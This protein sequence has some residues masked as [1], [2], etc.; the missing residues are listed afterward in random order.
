LDFKYPHRRL[1]NAAIE[2][3]FEEQRNES[4]HVGFNELYRKSLSFLN[5]SP[6]DYGSS[7]SERPS[8]KTFSH[9]LEKMEEEKI[10]K[11]GLK[12]RPNHSDFSLTNDAKIMRG[13]NILGISDDKMIFTKVYE[14]ILLSIVF[15]MP[16]KITPES[17]DEFLST[18]RA[19]RNGLPL[20][21]S[22][23]D[24]LNLSNLKLKY[25][26]VE[27][28]LNLNEE[29]NKIIKKTLFDGDMRF[30]LADDNLHQLIEV[31]GHLFVDEMSL[32][33]CKWRHFSQPS[34]EEK[35]RLEWLVGEDISRKIIRDAEIYRYDN[36]IARKSKRA[37]KRSK[38][39]EEYIKH[40]KRGNTS[41]F[42]LSLID[43]VFELYIDNKRK[44]VACTRSSENDI[45]EFFNVLHNRFKELETNYVNKI[46][47]VHQKYKDT[48]KKYR[49]LFQHVLNKICPLLLKSLSSRDSTP[50]L[51][52]RQY[53]DMRIKVA[54]IIESG[55]LH[56]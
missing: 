1:Y 15:R 26:I 24:F 28:L 3:L 5:K 18:F 12:A 34:E 52:N 14:Q 40:L 27:T 4:Y 50:A 2:A 56:R 19:N 33:N 55:W 39:V 16:T 42:E 35:E 32:L 9:V 30:I 22:T 43:S 48:I 41:E 7:R 10:V 37:E 6:N 51:F 44:N 20:G 29:Q 36:K 23:E 31:I 21:V 17:L 49:F 47:G 11:E 46:E 45:Q 8:R 13:L 38:N 25:K 53:V 54:K